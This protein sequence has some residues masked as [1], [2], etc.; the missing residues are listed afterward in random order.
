[1]KN[2]FPNRVF[3][4][5]VAGL[6]LTAVLGAG[7]AFSD[8][9]SAIPGKRQLDADGRMRVSEGDRCPVCAMEVIRYPK[10]ASAIA[11]TDGRTFYFCGTGCMI[12]TWLHPEVFLG[13]S[14]EA[15]DR[16]VVRDYFTGR[17]VD[18]RRVTWVAGS[19]VVGPMGPAVVP[20]ADESHV[21]TFQRRHG[22][23]HT[24]RLD[25]MDDAR[26]IEITGKPAVPKKQP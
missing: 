12:R 5:F 23:D 18:A 8:S 7:P 6:L 21:E 3:R 16:P 26:W 1:M 17:A 2:R 9:P 19:D 25:E 20:I 22:G 11:L 4:A 15:L 13:V 10:F 14:R 24:F